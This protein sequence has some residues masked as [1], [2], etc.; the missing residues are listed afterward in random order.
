MPQLSRGVDGESAVNHPAKVR[1]LVLC[2]APEG[3][4]PGQRFR[5]EQYLGVLGAAGIDVEVAPFLDPATSTILYASGSNFSKM[6]GVLVGFFHRLRL[7]SRFGDYDRIFI[8]REAAPLG[9]PI[10]EWLAFR[11]RKPVVYDFDDAIFIRN[12]SKANRL[13]GWL[14]FPSKVRY[15]TCRSELVMVCNDYLREWAN[16]LNGNAVIVPTTIDLDYHRS[17]RDRSQPAD[18]P[19][20][21]WTGS[22]STA[23]YLD[24]IRPALRE[25][26]RRREFEFRVICDKDP[27]FP[28]LKNYRFVPWRLETEIADLD[29][30]DIG[31]M[32]VP[33]GPWQRGKVGFKAIQYGA[34]E[35]PAVVS[36]TGAGGDVVR[37]GVTGLVVE[38][39]ADAWCHAL[40]RLIADSGRAAQMGREARLHVAASYSTAAQAGAYIN[41]FSGLR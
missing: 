33:D 25:L 6:A 31:V 17:S 4:S 11:S 22:H 15:I 16:E 7:A 28:E 13:I 29:M 27:G 32:P 8:F 3:R 36:A 41:A 10:I 26:E 35:M 39:S 34:M 14:K 2:P 18:R 21:G 24:L 38:N 1:A 30:F 23:P 40:E 20:V 9:P 5:F 12:V 37:H 19:V